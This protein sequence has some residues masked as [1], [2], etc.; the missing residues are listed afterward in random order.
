MKYKIRNHFNNE[1]IV[2]GEAD[3]FKEFVEQN[4]NNLRRADLREANLRG[5]DLWGADLQ[6]ADL[7]GADLR[8]ADLRE[9]NLREADLW[10][11]DLQGADLWGA[12]LREAYFGGIKITSSQ[13]DDIIK[14]LG[15]E[16][17]E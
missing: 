11:A 15:I 8:R 3:D 14:G 1:I 9:A 6:G 5:A 17:I 13:K 4:K 10:G 2:K 16:V 7:W 12:D